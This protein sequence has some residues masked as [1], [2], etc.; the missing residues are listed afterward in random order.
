M[1]RNLNPLGTQCGRAG[2]KAALSPG[3]SPPVSITLLQ[4]H[5]KQHFT[6]KHKV[7]MGILGKIELAL[8]SH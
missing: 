4:D 7:P 1:Y 6:V 3:Q 8:P 2:P 5:P